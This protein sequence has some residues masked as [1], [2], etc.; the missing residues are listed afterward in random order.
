MPNYEPNLTDVQSTLEVFPKGEYEFKITS[1]KSFEKS[2]EDGSKTVGIRFPMEEAESGKKTIYTLYVHS[3]GAMGFAK[4]FVMAAYGYS[5]DSE[6]ENKF[7]NDYRGA[8]W[9]IDTE[10]GTVG[11]IWKDLIGKRVVGVVDTKI[12]PNGDQQQEWNG[13]RAIS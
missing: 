8:D 12:G 5:V 3:E 6:G 10:N 9:S 1:A 11:E 4:R 7:N 13:F 2:K